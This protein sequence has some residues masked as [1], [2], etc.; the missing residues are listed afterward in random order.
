MACGK[1]ARDRWGGEKGRKLVQ[2]VRNRRDQERM[3]DRENNWEGRDTG[4]FRESHAADSVL[5]FHL[6]VHNPL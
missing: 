4:G 1:D 6:V 2:G 3:E 5:S